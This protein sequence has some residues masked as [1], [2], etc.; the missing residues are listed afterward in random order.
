[1]FESSISTSSED[2]IPAVSSPVPPSIPLPVAPSACVKN[3]DASCNWSIIPAPKI[4]GRKN[5]ALKKPLPFIFWFRIIAINSA[6]ITI[7]GI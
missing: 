6:K 1:M 7:A 3:L 4:T 5:I 2:T